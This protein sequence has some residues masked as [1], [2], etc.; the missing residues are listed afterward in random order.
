MSRRLI[1]IAVVPL[2]ALVSC[3]DAPTAPEAAQS[4]LSSL[5]ADTTLAVATT[6]MSGLNSPRGLA[7]GPGG[8]LYVAEAGTPEINGPCVAMARGDSCYSGT[9]SVS[10]LS[11]GGQERV[12]TGLPSTYN[13]ATM[14]V[15]GVQDLEFHADGS[16]SFT[17]G[18]GGAPE[19][20]AGFG[21]VGAH[22]GTL[23]RAT[24]STTGT[25]VDIA[26]F[27]QANNPAGGP[28]DSNPY[29]V[30]VEGSRRYVTDA[31]GNSLL[32]V[33][34]GQVSLIATFP[35]RPVPPPLGEIIPFSEAVPTEVHRGPDGALY[36]SILSG[37]PFPPGGAGIYRVVPGSEPELYAGFTAVLDFAFAPDGGVFVLEFAA[38]PFLGGN[39]SLVH[40]ARDGTRTVVSDQLTAPTSLLVGRDGSV[41]VA[42]QGM[43]PGMGEVVRFSRP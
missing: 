24:S 23:I 6:V 27:E 5:S 36:V 8:A 35:A 12:F 37:A 25:I 14:E 15:I 19:A 26:D 7:W 34:N 16:A 38:E 31:G 21:E 10:R 20:R 18:W 39:G 40:V 4:P 41:Y 9:G 11:R 13:P 3:T 43:A 2:M 17:V 1:P 42:N 28:L 29:G 30:L 22:L 32:E 33:R